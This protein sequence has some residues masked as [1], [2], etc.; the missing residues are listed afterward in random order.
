VSWSTRSTR[1]VPPVAAICAAFLALPTAFVLVVLGGV[2]LVLADGRAD[3]GV[4]M[5]LLLGVGWVVALLVGA[6][7]LLLG[8]SWLGLAVPAAALVALLLVRTVMGGLGGGASGFGTV[9]LVVAVATTVLAALPPTRRW[10]AEQRR[11]RL[12]PGPTQ[13]SP[14]RP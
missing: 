11:E 10:V 12:F 3:G 9:S 1:R 7:R 2:A 14:S 6:I 13:R 4:W 8:R 5:V